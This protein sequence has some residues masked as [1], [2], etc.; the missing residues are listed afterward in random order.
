MEEIVKIEMK[1][2]LK[3][4]DKVEDHMLVSEV[5]WSKFPIKSRLWHY[6]QMVSHGQYQVHQDDKEKYSELCA[7]LEKGR[8]VILRGQSGSGKS[9]LTRIISK[10]TY[11]IDHPKRYQF[12]SVFK[13]VEEFSAGGFPAIQKYYAGYWVFDDVG[14]E[15]QISKGTQINGGGPV[16]NVM[17]IILDNQYKN[18]P[19]GRAS[20]ILSTNL[21]DVVIDGQEVSQF[22]ILYTSQIATR[23]KQVADFIK[24]NGCN[25]RDRFPVDM[26]TTFPEVLH[27]PK[28]QQLSAEEKAECR[29]IAQKIQDSLI[30]LAN[31]FTKEQVN[32]KRDPAKFLKPTDFEQ[33]CWDWFNDTWAAQGCK[34]ANGLTGLPI[35]EYAGDTYTRESFVNMCVTL[36]NQSKDA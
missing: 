11:H 1:D 24:I 19:S 34:L 29:K 33:T 12:A 35:I 18:I 9:T 7:A 16:Y 28:D 30:T 10:I 8:S 23:I 5:C 20:F 2:W 32:E 17:G 3:Q 21:G 4:F 14:R 25:Y 26:I 6:A 15:M 31:K 36:S 22:E 27:A 13:I